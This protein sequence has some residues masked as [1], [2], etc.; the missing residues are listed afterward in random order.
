MKFADGRHVDMDRSGLKSSEQLGSKITHKVKSHHLAMDSSHA[1]DRTGSNGYRRKKYF[2]LVPVLLAAARS[3]ATESWQDWLIW[4]SC[5]FRSPQWFKHHRRRPRFSA[6][7]ICSSTKSRNK[8][9]SLEHFVELP[10]LCQG[11]LAHG[12]Y[13]PNPHV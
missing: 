1:L 8:C 12:V 7:T 10:L 13:T 3:P 5:C 2:R 9:F 6:P 4:L 11:P